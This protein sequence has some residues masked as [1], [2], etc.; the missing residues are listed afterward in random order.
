MCTLFWYWNM[1]VVILAVFC[2]I[3]RNCCGMLSIICHLKWPAACLTRVTVSVL[4]WLL[5][6]IKPW[7]TLSHFLMYVQCNVTHNV[8]S[9]LYILEYWIWIA[10]FWRIGSLQSCA[11]YLVLQKYKLHNQS[12]IYWFIFSNV[13][14]TLKKEW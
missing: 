3:L 1:F 10:H 12:V 13:V 8:W 2:S 7:Y 4:P 9:L 5:R 14:L 6:S 11:Q